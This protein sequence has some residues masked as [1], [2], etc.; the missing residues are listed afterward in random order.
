MN[1]L[2][3][4]DYGLTKVRTVIVNNEPWFV[5][6]D[7]CE[8]FGDTNYRRSLSRID[9]DEKGVSQID[10]LGGMQTMTIVNESG[11][12]SLLFTMQPQKGN[13]PEEQYLSR[14]EQIKQ[15]K[16]WITHEVIPAIRK[17]GFYS[18]QPKFPQNYAEALRELADAWEENQ[19]LLPKAQY[20]DNLVDRNL[21]TN[22]RDTAK[23]LKVKEG[24][25]IDWLLDRGY[26]YRDATKKLKPYAQYVPNLFEIKEWGKE[27]KAGT[28]TL[29]T[30]RGR[31]T[32]RLLLKGE[33]VP[34]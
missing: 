15:F 31:E 7:I 3:V 4:F 22:F 8:H 18:L 1:H 23:E 2:Q 14:I 13:L 24:I 20:F 30:P 28:Q 16:R 9:D 11:L 5:G 29:I 6:K 26:V 33:L 27:K 34:V 17:T 21:L 32:F 25:F 10:T 19:K 12:Y